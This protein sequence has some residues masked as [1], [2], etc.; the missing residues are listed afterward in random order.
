M[1]VAFGVGVRGLDVFDAGFGFRLGTA[2]DPDCGV[3]LIK[4][5]D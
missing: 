3:V 4:D 2:G 1:E 5:G